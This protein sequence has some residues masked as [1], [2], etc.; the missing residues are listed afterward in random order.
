MWK[1]TAEPGRPEMTI[2]RMC[3]ACWITRARNARSGYVIH[4]ALPRQQRSSERASMLR[5]YVYC[6]SCSYVAGTLVAVPYVQ[7]DVYMIY[8]LH[9]RHIHRKSYSSHVKFIKLRLIPICGLNNRI[10]KKE[11]NIQIYES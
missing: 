10:K 6:L 9:H 5:L 7:P 4:F 11:S 1:N 2:W 8:R 3:T